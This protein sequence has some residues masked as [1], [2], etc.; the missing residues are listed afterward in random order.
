M[1]RARI[2]LTALLLALTLLA[3]PLTATPLEKSP[4]SFTYLLA[5]LFETVAAP[6]SG[7]LEKS[8]DTE[9]RLSIDP[10]GANTDPTDETTERRLHIDPDGATATDETT[11]GQ[12]SIDPN[13]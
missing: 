5:S 4:F 6:F 10:N 7:V 13:G 8:E 3:A 1:A 2:T 12:L 11:E 9:G